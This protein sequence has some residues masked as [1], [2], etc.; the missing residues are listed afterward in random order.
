MLFR[1]ALILVSIGLVILTITQLVWPAFTN[2]PFFPIF[3]K[4]SA[5]SRAA[6]LKAEALEQKETAELEAE[7]IRLDTEAQKIRDQAFSDLVDGPPNP[8]KEPPK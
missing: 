7:A 5:L 1:L 8:I 4:E 6:R 2:R 3:R